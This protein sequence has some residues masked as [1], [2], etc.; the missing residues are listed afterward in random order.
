MNR[1]VKYLIALCLLPGAGLQAEAALNAT[2]TYSFAESTPLASGKWV[3]IYI[4]ESG[5]YELSYSKLREM[6]FPNPE[7][8]SVFG[9]G[10]VMYPVNFTD[11]NLARLMEDTPQQV[12]VY[13]A[14]DKLYFYGRGVADITFNGRKFLR[15]SRNIY[16][17]EGVYLLTDSQPVRRMQEAG[18]INTEGATLR[19]DLYDYVYHEEDNIHNFSDSGQLFWD[20]DFHETPRRQWDL[21]L[22]YSQRN[23]YNTLDI[24]IVAGTEENGSVHYG[25][26]QY[27]RNMSLKRQSANTY[28]ASNPDCK[29]SLDGTAQIIVEAVNLTDAF[30]GF[31]YW[32]FSYRKQF[33]AGDDANLVQERFTLPSSSPN[34]V[35]SCVTVP[36]GVIAFDVTDPYNPVMLSPDNSRLYF[37]GDGQSH[38][39]IIFNPEKEQKVTDGRYTTVPNQDLHARAQEGADLLIICSDTQFTWGERI[40]ELHR[41]N[42]GIK[43]MVVTAQQLYNEFTSGLTDP[44]AYRSMVKMLYQSPVQMKNVLF[45][46][47]IFA[48]VRNVTHRPNRSDG[49]IAYQEPGVI[50]TRSAA[51]AMDYFGMAADYIPNIYDISQMP[52]NAG[53]GVL[54]LY[55]SEEGSIAYNKIREY[56]EDQ[57]FDW[58]VNETLSLSCPGDGY[59]HDQQAISIQKTINKYTSQLYNSK[60]VHDMQSIEYYGFEKT[61]NKFLNAM[62]NGKLLSFYFGHADNVGIA[63]NTLF[64]NSS[65]LESLENKNLGFMF[66]AGCELSSTD[67]GIPGI[68]EICVTRAPRGLVGSIMATRTVWSNYNYDLAAAF[69]RGFYNKL[70]GSVRT[71]TPTIGEVFSFGKS[72]T[73]KAN[74]LNYILIGDP[75]LK[76]PLALR[77]IDAEVVNPKP[78]AGGEVITVKGKI[79]NPNN[80]HDRTFNGKVSLKLMAPRDSAAYHQTVVV[81]DVEVD[82]AIVKRNDTTLFYIDLNQERLTSVRVDVKNGEF[83]AKLNVPENFAKYIN[84]GDGRRPVPLHI[85]AYDRSSWTGASAYIEL[86]AIAYGETPADDRE[87]DTEAPEVTC[88]YDP[89]VRR[90]KFNV[91]DNVAV[92]A[93]IGAGGSVKAS[94]DGKELI[95]NQNKDFSCPVTEFSSS[96]PVFDYAEGKHTVSYTARDESGNVSEQKSLTFT[97]SPASAMT[98]AATNL[99]GVDEVSFHLSGA[100]QGDFELMIID[101]RGNIIATEPVGSGSYIWD[102]T[103][104]A[105]GI[106]RAVVRENSASGTTLFSNW[107]EFCLID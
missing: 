29:M 90:L 81:R 11:T 5:I 24:Q 37:A 56:M 67:Q 98:L 97:I 91:T 35:S 3:K 15:E 8:V 44:M 36:N 52:L 10:G 13:Y 95:L 49:L 43:V 86:D 39:V 19:T 61:R 78:L 58:V 25:V 103:G 64:I 53:V 70:D 77:K 63:D 96:V 100:Q 17:N 66:F 16:S 31:D 62:T 21:D 92:R 14:S 83:I 80:E 54:P 84:H 20:Y 27:Y 104:I 22:P 40:A 102:A 47:Q 79:L 38:N 48:D 75:A 2:Y 105:A 89:L 45:M 107:I 82:G 6:G 93:G 1:I 73:S 76:V 28:L 99:T 65:N 87:K 72:Q 68:G 106:Y 57:D 32:M 30:A 26:G 34:G 51:N 88:I 23:V 7:N 55:S 69:L 60:Y 74:D 50:L 46:G 101:K 41:K 94:V 33:L 59:A 12:P 85:G 4:P 42:D 71:E 18:N 9:N